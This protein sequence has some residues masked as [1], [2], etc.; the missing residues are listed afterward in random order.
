LVGKCDF[1][2]LLL[3]SITSLENVCFNDDERVGGRKGSDDEKHVLADSRMCM[4][5]IIR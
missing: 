3:E 1:C 4:K 5:K 2:V